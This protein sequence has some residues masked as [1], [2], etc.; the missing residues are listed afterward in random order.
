MKSGLKIVE[1]FMFNLSD[2]SF[3]KKDTILCIINMVSI[4]Y[5][6]NR[7]LSKEIYLKL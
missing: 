6:F 7:D 3:E 4:G 1:Y 2:C 5:I